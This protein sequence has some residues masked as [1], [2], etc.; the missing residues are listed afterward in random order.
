MK[1]VSE[2]YQSVV[3]PVRIMQF[4]EGNFLRAFV[5]Y[6]VDAANE[7]QGFNGNV[8]VII[9]RSGKSERF[10]KQHNIYTVCLR[11]QK[12]GKVYTEDRVITSIADVISARDEYDK[13][14]ALAQTDTL[15]FVVSNTT[16]AGIVFDG[17]DRFD[18]CPPATFPAKLTKFLW[19]R[20]TFYKGAA[21]KG[22]VMLPTELIDH[23]GKALETCVCQY[24]ETWKLGAEFTDWLHASCSFV[25]TLVDR[26]V[27]GF[28]KEEAAALWQELG[29]ED[30][31]LD[32]AEPFS[33]WAVGDPSLASR[34]PFASHAFD[35]AF[36]DDIKAYKE[37]KVRILNGA[38][39]SMV[40]GAY[41]AGLDY[42]GQCMKDPVIR[43][44][45]DQSVFDEIV[46][47]VHLP[48]EKA[49]AFAKAV[50][51]RFE[52][53]F[54]NHALLSI[55]LNSVS[56]WKARVLPTFKDSVAATGKLPKWL[57]YSFAAFL[58]FYRTTVAGDHCLIG[59]RSTNTYE[60]HDDEEAL[61]FFKDN[62]G[63]S[64]AAYVTAIMS[65]RDFW[66]ED[67]TAIPGFADAVI[68]H[69]DRMAAVGV[70]AHIEELGKQ[71]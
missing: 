27:T 3:R 50:Y 16:E 45:L 35:I 44:Q 67:L 6:A 69:L 13:F 8:A 18:A 17:A 10:A 47:T 55:S 46:P 30:D 9:P 23:N 43:T 26:I 5:D 24:A 36:T 42:V 14:M 1:N 62:A 15:E 4:G 11:G 38:H 53:P 20:F 49:V 40:L 68:A 64:T 34:L 39:T 25:D 7:E 33:L 29:Y 61:H 31:L 71:A 48:R 32:K 70:K 59:S 63:K 21:D 28:P 56:K 41:L 58:A 12:D 66:G 37:Q 51:E 19:Q 54:V 22:L 52:N 60:I 65:H 2:L 57:T